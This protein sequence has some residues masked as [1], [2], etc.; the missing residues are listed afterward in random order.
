MSRDRV[1]TPEE[2]RSTV[3]NSAQSTSRLRAMSSDTG[4]GIVNAEAV[5]DEDPS[6]VDLDPNSNAQLG[7]AA[8][9]LLTS[10]FVLRFIKR[11]IRG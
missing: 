5:V 3:I 7:A 9:G 1:L 10:P 8:V 2:V 4:R 11:K 6:P